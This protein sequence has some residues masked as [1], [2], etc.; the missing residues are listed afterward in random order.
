[1]RGGLAG[2]HHRRATFMVY[3]LILIGMALTYVGGEAI[4]RGGAGLARLFKMSPLLTGLIVIT[5]G[6]SIPEWMVTSNALS[7]D[8]PDLA[9]G[10]IVGSNI[11]NIF[12]ILGVGALIQALPTSPK[13]VFKDG[14]VMIG[15][16]IA[17][18][19]MT[20]DG[21]IGLIDGLVL[22]A[23]FLFYVAGSF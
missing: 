23:G 6:S 17:L 15:A 9:M 2:P 1:L 3:A 18:W 8:A 11:T 10:T 22:F 4:V 12:L 16:S 7:R 14:G 20:M 21:S 5:F 13:V 19:L